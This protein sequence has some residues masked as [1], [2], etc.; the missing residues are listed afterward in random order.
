MGLI[1]IGAGALGWGLGKVG[2]LGNFLAGKSTQNPKTSV[3]GTISAVLAGLGYTFP[4]DIIGWLDLG[5]Q[6][7]QCL[8]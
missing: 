5:K 4:P 8:Q 7:A 2:D 1:N 3:F 6:V